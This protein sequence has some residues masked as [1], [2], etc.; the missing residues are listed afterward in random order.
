MRAFISIAGRSPSFV[1]FLN[2]ASSPSSIPFRIWVS[3]ARMPASVSAS[4][5]AVRMTKQ[6]RGPSGP[7]K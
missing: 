1:A 5:G 6:R 7:E 4:A 3:E 2:R